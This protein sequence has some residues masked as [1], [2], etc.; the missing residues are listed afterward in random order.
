MHNLLY[1]MKFQYVNT[2]M[3]FDCCHRNFLCRQ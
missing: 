1:I 3:F 2:N